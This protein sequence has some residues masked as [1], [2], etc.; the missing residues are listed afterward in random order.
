MGILIPFPGNMDTSTAPRPKR[1]RSMTSI[2]LSWLSERMTRADELKEQISSGNY[3][4]PIDQVA[5]AIVH[6]E[7]ENHSEVMEKEV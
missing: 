5:K 7:S 4:I 3:Q 2:A 1:K 6:P